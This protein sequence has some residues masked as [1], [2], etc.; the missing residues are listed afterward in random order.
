MIALQAV[1]IIAVLPFTHSRCLWG[2]PAPEFC[3]ARR[4]TAFDA[5]SALWNNWNITMMMGNHFMTWLLNYLYC[6]GMP[7][8]TTHQWT[9]MAKSDL[10]NS[11]RWSFESPWRATNHTTCGTALFTFMAWP[12]SETENDYDR[13]M[14]R[15][16]TR[17]QS[18]EADLL[19]VLVRSWILF[20]TIVIF[21]SHAKQARYFCSC[22]RLELCTVPRLANSVRGISGPYHLHM[23]V[24]ALWLYQSALAAMTNTLGWLA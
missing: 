23:S 18:S 8:A 2:A 4:N 13:E 10:I 21:L 7:L 24:F 22:W 12:F 5:L 16:K 14:D 15:R 17:C 3:L 1:I 11:S 6:N 9:F 19:S 20:K